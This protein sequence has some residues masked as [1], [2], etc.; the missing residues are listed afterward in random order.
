M[1]IGETVRPGQ[2]L[3]S[4]LSLARLRVEAE[5][6]QGDVA[7]IRDHASAAVL[8]DDGRRLQA[9]RVVVFPYADP[10]THSFRV[11]VELVVPG[12]ELVVERTV[13]ENAGH[14]DAYFALRDAFRAVGRQL[15]QRT[16]RRGDRAKPNEGP[17]A[18]Q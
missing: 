18:R 9:Q 7:A 10:R 4:G 11:R 15:H 12:D 1:R 5:I 16:V 3:V 6:P 14:Q 13:T 17:I 2:A 8:L